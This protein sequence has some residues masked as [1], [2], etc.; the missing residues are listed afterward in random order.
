[1]TLA[2]IALHILSR[3]S[4]PRELQQAAHDFLLRSFEADET[5][6]KS[7]VRTDSQILAGMLASFDEPSPT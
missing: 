5:E 7:V 2:E 1:M 6:T 3:D 4:L